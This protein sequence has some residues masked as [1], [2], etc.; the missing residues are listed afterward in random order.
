MNLFEGAQNQPAYRAI[1]SRGVVPA[2]ATEDAVIVESAAIA[3]LAFEE[4]PKSGLA[5]DPGTPERAAYL[6]WCIFGPAEL[7]HHLVTI[8]QNTM[9]LPEDQRDPAKIAAA[10]ESLS[11]RW[12]FLEEGLGDRSY[13][14][15][16]SFSGADVVVGHSCAWAN[17]L[18]TLADNPRL[19]AYLG[20]LAKRPAF[21]KV[22]GG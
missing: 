12:A 10:K 6:Q 1:Q 14:I 3:M 18:G 16:D 4:N 17:M 11:A 20:E 13:L 7:D 22:Y 5:P 9:L 15:G 8:T 2:L 21:Q 19:Q